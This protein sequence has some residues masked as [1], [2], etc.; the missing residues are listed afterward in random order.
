MPPA[1]YQAPTFDQLKDAFG[2]KHELTEIK[3]DVRTSDVDEFIK[4][5]K[6]AMKATKEHSI[7]FG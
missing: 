7:Q 2:D 5:L 1:I 4:N 3:V 6:D